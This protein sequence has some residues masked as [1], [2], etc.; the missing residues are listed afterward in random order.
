[1]HHPPFPIG[2]NEF[3]AIAMLEGREQFGQLLRKSRSDVIVLSGHIHRPYQATW[4]GASCYIAGGPSLQMGSHFCFGD[5]PLEVVDEPYAYF[6]HDI[7]GVA[8]HRVG[9]RYVKFEQPPEV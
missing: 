4:N 5:D 2:Q 3:D 6:I 1:M 9:L 7:D 8:G